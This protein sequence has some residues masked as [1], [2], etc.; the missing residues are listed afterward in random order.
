MKP[1]EIWLDNV[2]RHD[3]GSYSEDDLLLK[4][5]RAQ[6]EAFRA[7]IQWAIE[8]LKEQE[9]SVIDCGC[10]TENFRYWKWLEDRANDH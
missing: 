10:F 7:G 1:A 2:D 9:K 6:D 3:S 5:K 4:F 8:Q